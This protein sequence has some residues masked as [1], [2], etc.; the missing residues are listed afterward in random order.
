MKLET[1]KQEYIAINP[2]L[3]EE[4]QTERYEEE[5][6]LNGQRVGG[7]ATKNGLVQ[8]NPLDGRT[9]ERVIPWE[10]I[11]IKLFAIIREYKTIRVEIVKD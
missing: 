3:I 11:E 1:L 4:K 6:F 2:Q 10:E 9:I 8:Y 5:Y 7:L